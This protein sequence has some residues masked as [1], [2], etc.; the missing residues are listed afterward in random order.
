MDSYRATAS[1]GELVRVVRHR[2]RRS[3]HHRRRRSLTRP[4]EKSRWAPDRIG[5]D[6]HAA[7][8]GTKLVGGITF[9]PTAEGWLYLVRR[10]DLAAVEV[11]GYVMADHRRA[12]LVVD[13][14]CRYTTAAACSPDTSRTRIAAAHTHEPHSGAGQGT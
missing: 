1:A 13:A 2:H 10:L 3:F 14:P 7:R 8:P 4:D 12:S 6:F 5:R 11:D 9:L